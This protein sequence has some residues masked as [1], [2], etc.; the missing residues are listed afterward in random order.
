MLK[1]QDIHIRDP[2]VLTDMKNN[3]YVMYGTIG[4]TA[5]SGRPAGFDAYVSDD[6]E[7]WEGPIAAFRP[8]EHF[9]SDQDY[10]APEVHEYNGAYY[11]FASFKAKN[12]PRATQILNADSPLGPF[13]PHTEKPITPAEWECLDGTMYVD[14]DQQPW[15][16]F[17]REW[18]EVR[19]GQIWAAP[20]TSDLKALQAEPTMLFRASEAPWA[21]AIS[22]AKEYVTDGPFL[23]RETDGRLF[24]LWSSQGEAGYAMG[25]AISES[26]E[27]LGP[28]HQE[29]EPLFGENGGHGMI[30]ASLAGERFISLHAPNDHPL[31]RPV[32]LLMR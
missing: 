29:E 21:R 26:G 24:M 25:R 17:C 7:N 23:Y 4:E 3:R 1:L 30:F 10:W 15:L 31:E 6:L 28:W 11:M 9:W 32:F 19:D 27:V 2:F 14:S 22:E 16:V 13:V 8:E 5:W 12:M 20:L 18:L